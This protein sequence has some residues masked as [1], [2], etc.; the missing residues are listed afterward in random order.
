[1]LKPDGKTCRLSV[2]TAMLPETKMYSVTK[3]FNYR[4][5]SK[6]ENRGRSVDD[7]RPGN[8]ELQ[9]SSRGMVSVR[10]QVSLRQR[11]TSRI[12]DCLQAIYQCFFQ[13]ERPRLFFQTLF[14]SVFS[15]IL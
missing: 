2:V 1:M 8:T 14:I 3:T 4:R 9:Q 10:R 6:T 11:F 5:V 15:C 13:W 12:V 7:N